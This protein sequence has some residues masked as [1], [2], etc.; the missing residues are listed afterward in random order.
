MN[1]KYEM[2][3]K[4][5]MG[6]ENV[7]AEELNALGADDVQIGRRMV[8]FKGDK[9]M[10]YRANFE[11]H[12]ALKIAP[13]Y[14]GPVLWMKD[15]SQNVIAS[16]RLLNPATRAELTDELDKKYAELRSEQSDEKSGMV[17]LEE[18]RQRKPKYFLK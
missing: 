14:H 11:L 7:L 9:E 10:M 1:T 18:A 12:T 15:A 17:S 3:A 13:V 6:L 16:A 2:I 5:F 8:S 4:T